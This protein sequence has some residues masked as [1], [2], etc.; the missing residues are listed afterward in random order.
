MPM[1]VSA[2][3]FWLEHKQEFVEP[4]ISELEQGDFALDSAGFTAMSLWKRKGTQRG[5]LG[6]FPWTLA[7]YV[8]LAGLLRPM[9]WSQPDACVEP[10]IAGNEEARCFRIE[11]TAA[12]LEASLMLVDR[13]QSL[14]AWWQSPPV[15]VLQGWTADEYMRSLD[16]MIDAWQRYTHAFDMPALVGVGSMCRRPV[17]D[18]DIGILS[19]LERLLPRLPDGMRLHM[20]GVKG[21]VMSRLATIP[22]VASFDSMAWD[23]GARM[24]ARKEGSSN[25]LERRAGEMKRWYRAQ[26]PWHVQA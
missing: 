16:L 6:M 18:P 21:A 1:M 26:A 7:E 19:I 10:D 2:S 13:W 23:F 22:Q 24:M 25:T 14:G 20:F 8:E 3:A 12:M 5:M 11:A 15:P 17:H 9:W 4:D